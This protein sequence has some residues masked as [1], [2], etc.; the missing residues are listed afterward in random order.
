MVSIFSGEGHTI[1]KNIPCIAKA[2][3]PGMFP[4]EINN[5]DEMLITIYDDK[6]CRDI[7]VGN[8]DQIEKMLPTNEVVI[9]SQDGRDYELI[10]SGSLEEAKIR[11]AKLSEET[12]QELKIEPNVP[13]DK[14][15]NNVTGTR[16][17]TY[18]DNET[19]SVNIS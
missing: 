14:W 15:E 11:L 19:V 7:M 8:Y 4:L 10:F 5:Y 9:F 16:F 3:A 13:K 2:T 12:G 18:L 6:E 1:S 17:F